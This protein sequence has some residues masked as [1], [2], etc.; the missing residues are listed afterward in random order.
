MNL[1]RILQ[2]LFFCLV[3]KGLRNG[4]AQ[5]FRWPVQQIVF[6]VIQIKTTTTKKRKSDLI[7][8]K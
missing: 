3:K 5:L 7:E 1:E 6:A 4:K 8:D 2:R